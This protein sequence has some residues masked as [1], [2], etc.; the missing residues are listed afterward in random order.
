[1]SDEMKIGC[2]GL[3]SHGSALVRRVMARHRVHVFDE[4]AQAMHQLEVAGAIVVKDLPSLARSCDVV[5]ICGSDGKQVRDV[6]L[7]AN[8]LGE[9]LTP[10]KIIVDMTMALPP[11]TQ[12]LAADLL[13]RGVHLIDAPVQ[14]ELWAELDRAGTILCGGHSASVERIR[15]I[16]EAICAKIVYAG[17][18]GSGHAAKLLTSALA[19][20]NRFIT[21][22]CAAV[23]FK[24]GLSIHH[25]ATVLNNASGRNTASEIVLPALNMG[26][27]TADI[28]LHEAVNDLRHTSEMA[29]SCGAPILIANLVYGLCE[30]AANQLGRAATLDDVRR[31][32]ES[33]AATRLVDA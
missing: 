18:S 26:V 9:G 25:M 4:S 32:Y 29:M 19:T 30:A 13:K 2:F 11:K 21:Y 31:L 16:L 8:G 27:R 7:G 1:M 5:V 15:P 22:E 12:A 23:G 3:Q 14:T 10:G 24:Q 33:I 20:C 28:E 17:E 6:V